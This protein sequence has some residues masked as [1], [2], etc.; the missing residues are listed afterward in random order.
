MPLCAL[1]GRDGQQEDP[2]SPLFSLSMSQD[3]PYSLH[4]T[5]QVISLLG[6]NEFKWAQQRRLE[7][8]GGL[9]GH[10]EVSGALNIN[11][12]QEF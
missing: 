6:S 5:P 8:E 1:S 11:P 7:G 12:L 9:G 10:P 2:A 3:F 4:E